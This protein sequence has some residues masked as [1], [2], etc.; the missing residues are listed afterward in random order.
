[1]ISHVD[2]IQVPIHSFNP[3]EM[4]TAPE[5]WIEICTWVPSTW[6]SIRWVHPC[7]IACLPNNVV[8]MLISLPYI[9]SDP[10]SRTIVL[11]QLKKMRLLHLQTILLPLWTSF[12]YNKKAVNQ[13]FSWVW[14][15]AASAP[16]WG[17]LTST[18]RWS[19]IVQ[20]YLNDC[21]KVSPR[22][23]WLT[24]LCSRKYSSFVIYLMISCLE[25]VHDQ[26]NVIEFHED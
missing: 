10:Q 8:I 12:P 9:L 23:I 7:S 26:L 24:P 14:K 2:N 1:M 5:V 3:P 20:D 11:I 19:W 16:L 18:W 22:F 13:P 15:R 25:L 17:I 21:M 4:L 6:M